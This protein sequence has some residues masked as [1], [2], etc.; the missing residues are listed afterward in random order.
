MLPF[1]EVMDAR[2]CVEEGCTRKAVR[3]RCKAVTRP[4]AADSNAERQSDKRELRT[5]LSVL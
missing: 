4:R 1:W 2:K 3:L 5:P